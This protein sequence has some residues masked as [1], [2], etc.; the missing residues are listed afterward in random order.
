MFGIKK[1]KH[2]KPRVFLGSLTIEPRSSL[3]K[4]EE[5]GFYKNVDSDSELR[6]G[7]EEIFCLPLASEVSEPLKT[8]LVLDVVIP[9]FLLGAGG[10]IDESLGGLPF[11]WRPNI[12]VR[13]RLYSLKSKKTKYTFSATAVISGWRFFNSIFS[14]K[15]LIGAY[16][17]FG[18]SDIEYLLFK[19]CSKI[20]QDIDKKI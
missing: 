18:K 4:V 11:F 1:N 2:S 3:K 20:L 6:K 14:F 5:W 7:L 9:K 8:D 13:A 12:K 19:A 17:A 10:L 15:N 16:P